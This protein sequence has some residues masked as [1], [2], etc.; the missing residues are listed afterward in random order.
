MKTCIVTT[1]WLDNEIYKQ[2]LIKLLG[3][4][5]TELRGLNFSHFYII[6]NGSDPQEI[7]KIQSLVI[8]EPVSFIRYTEHFDRPSHLDYKY[9]WRSVYTM[10]DILKNYDK[11]IYIDSDF[12]ILSSKMVDY[13]N[14][15]DSGFTTFF[16][17]KHGFPETGSYV[18]TKDCKNYSNFVNKPW[19]QFVQDNNNHVMETRLPVTHIEKNLTGNRYSEYPMDIPDDA[20]FSGQTLLETKVKFK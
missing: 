4:Y 5:L 9:L 8:G 3:Y 20:D 11:V 13:I 6:D 2:K 1:I 15:L 12:Y 17:P 14:K 19:D 10:K 18:L 7:R 16:C